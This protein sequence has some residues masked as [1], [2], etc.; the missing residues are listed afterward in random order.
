MNI[1]VI[2]ED[3]HIIAVVKPAGVL[4]QPDKTGDVSIMEEVKKYL[5]EKYHKPGNVFLGLLHRLDRPVSGIMLFAKTSK[6]AS[7]LSE[8]FRNHQIDKTY[9]AL[10][11]GKPT[12][13]R[14][15]LTNV[16]IKDEKLKKGR[17]KEGGKEAHLHY[18]VLKTNGTYSLLQISIEEGQFH[19]IRTQLSLA[20]LPILGDIKYGAKDFSWTDKQSIALAATGISFTPA[21]ELGKVNLSIKTPKEWDK[22]FS[23]PGA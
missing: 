17:E 14:G 23:T 6:G 22:Y 20:G 18:E 2:Y 16:L 8:Q 9:Q 3:N 12:K 1:E 7:R 15:V 10:V 4:S 21:T 5:K 19:Q 13:D 11:L